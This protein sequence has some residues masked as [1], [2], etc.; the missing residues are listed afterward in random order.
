MGIY[1]REYYRDETS[2]S[3]WFSGVAPACKT[4]VAINV[5]VYLAQVLLPDLGRNQ[6]GLHDLFAANSEAILRHFK[7]WQLLTAPFLH[8]KNDFFHIL[9]NMLFLWMVGREME[10]MYGSREF[11]FLYLTAA[12]FSTLCW[13]IVDQ[14]VPGRGGSMVGA[15]GAVMAIVMLYTLYYPRREILLFFVLPVQTWLLLLV[16]LVSNALMLL[17]QLQG[18]G[19]LHQSSTAFAAHLGGALYGYLYKT[20]DLRW[21]RLLDRRNRRPRLR[22]IS[23]EPRERERDRPRERPS[24]LPT[25][26][27][28]SVTASTSPRPASPAMFPEEQLDARL[29]EVLAKIARSGRAGLTEEENHILQEA[30]R[31]ARDRRSDRV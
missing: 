23:P 22:V 25:T 19:G 8:D 12:V 18:G 6:G 16:F 3:G 20:F 10:A 31:R 2:G 14:M 24:P 21:S 9:W 1:D 28:R 30:S 17:Q 27:S 29:D 4:I 5:L 15:S 13:A 11:T 26:S 7:L